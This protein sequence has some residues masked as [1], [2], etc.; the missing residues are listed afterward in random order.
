MV[1]RDTLGNDGRLRTDV[2]P[3]GVEL[4]VPNLRRGRYR[5][6]YWDTSVGQARE[7]RE[8]TAA[9]EQLTLVPAAV[10]T[11]LAIVIRRIGR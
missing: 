7:V 1:R 4:R 3:A 2:P 11:D 9:G 10:T 5:V 8:L 6:M